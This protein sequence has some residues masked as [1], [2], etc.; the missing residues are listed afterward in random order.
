MTRLR[1]SLS[2]LSLLIAVQTAA[3]QLISVKTIPISQADQFQIFPSRASGMGQVSIALRDTL[4][5]MGVNPA[6]G[7]RLGESQFFS[8]PFLYTVSNDAGAGRSLPMG[9]VG[10]L[11]SWFG[12]VSAALQQIDRS[13]DQ[14]GPVPF[15]L[16]TRSGTVPIDDGSHGNQFIFATAGK[17]LSRQG[18]SVGASLFWAE[19]HSMDGV[20]RLYA[21]SQSVRQFGHATDVRVGLLKEWTRG[22]A[23]E[24]LVLYNRFAMTHDV[25]FL[26]AIWDPGTMTVFQ[27]AREE[28]NVDHTSVHGVHLGYQMPLT[29]AGVRAGAVL[30]F[31]RM[32]H[33]KIP[34]YQFVQV[35]RIPWDPGHTNA[36]DIGL[37]I[38]KADGPATFGADL[39]IE[40]IRTHTWA[41]AQNAVTTRS[42]AAIPAGG[43]TVENYFHFLNAI[44]RLGVERNFGSTVSAQLGLLVN[45]VQ[46]RFWQVDHVQEA[47]RTQTVNWVETIPTW[48]IRLR[49]PEF[50]LRY[51]G[52]VTGGTGRPG[53]VPRFGGVFEAGSS[54]VAGDIL[55]PPSAASTNLGNV[56]L[57]THRFSIALPLGGTTRRGGAR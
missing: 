35:Q 27:R 42:G 46:Y 39:I 36:F 24:A 5:D 20:D 16:D 43:R 37:G 9:T 41:E 57:Y 48:G 14:T 11:G 44:I 7:A 38:S 56:S 50:E 54:V 25:T 23:F 1:F 52:S 33:P 18:L 15:A 8:A 21:G 2:V 12:G 30:T 10:R 55:S 32:S 22:G 40:P 34:E 3:A 13:R 49:Y 28:H 6:K 26:D 17:A 47:G 45:P 51:Q 29:A 53:V 31:N 4:F 19:I